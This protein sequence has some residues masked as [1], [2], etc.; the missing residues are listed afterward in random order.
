MP[1]NLHKMQRFYASC[2]LAKIFI[3]LQ[4]F[5]ASVFLS[6]SH[7]CSLIGAGQFG[8]EKIAEIVRT[9]LMVLFPACYPPFHHPLYRGEINVRCAAA[10]CSH[11]DFPR[12][13]TAWRVKF[14]TP[15]FDVCEEGAQPKETRE[16]LL[17]IEEVGLALASLSAL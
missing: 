11:Y 4:F 2:T 7:N 8:A 3:Q 5:H 16:T 1:L 9:L 6:W 17:I 12:A 14:H 10:V 15:P 13:F